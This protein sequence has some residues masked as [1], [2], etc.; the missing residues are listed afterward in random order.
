MASPSLK[1][2]ITEEPLPPLL[3]QLSDTCLECLSNIYLYQHGLDAAD[4][5]TKAIARRV[6]T[7][8]ESVS[9]LLA[10]QCLTRLS[11]LSVD[12]AWTTPMN[13]FID[14]M[15]MMLAIED[16]LSEKRLREILLNPNVGFAPIV[17]A[18]E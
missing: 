5:A 18:Q 7:N 15:Q 16:G 13:K 1:Y 14:M 12:Y 3:G 6:C 17:N 4:I 11:Q 2:R 10:R 8:N 9:I